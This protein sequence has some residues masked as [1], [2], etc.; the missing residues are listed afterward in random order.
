MSEQDGREESKDDL[1]APEEEGIT[2]KIEY[3]GIEG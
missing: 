2:P 1:D 3:G